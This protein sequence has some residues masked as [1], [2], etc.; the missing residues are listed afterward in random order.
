LNIKR[1]LIFI[2]TI[3]HNQE[4]KNQKNVQNIF[5]NLY[6]DL[7]DIIENNLKNKKMLFFNLIQ[8]YFNSHAKGLTLLVHPDIIDKTSIKTA[9]LR[10][11][12]TE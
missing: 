7:N 4:V 8:Y 9:A 2:E 3:D 6:K 10:P 11:S 1:N 5:L 12:F